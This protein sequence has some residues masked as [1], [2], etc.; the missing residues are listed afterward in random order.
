MDQLGQPRRGPLPEGHP[1]QPAAYFGG[2]APH[3]GGGGPYGGH[4]GDANAGTCSFFSHSFKLD[5]TTALQPNFLA[6]LV[7]LT[8]QDQV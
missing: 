3:G 4:D 8:D 7:L 5:Y 2:P 6:T 1:L